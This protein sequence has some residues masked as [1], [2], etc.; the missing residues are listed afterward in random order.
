MA[1]RPDKEKTEMSRLTPKQNIADTRTD[2]QACRNELVALAAPV[3]GE[4]AAR[5]AVDRILLIASHNP[6]LAGRIVDEERRR[7]SA[8]KRRITPSSNLGSNGHEA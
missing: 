5:L 1:L 2:T 8:L 7:W 3:L 4:D 6:S